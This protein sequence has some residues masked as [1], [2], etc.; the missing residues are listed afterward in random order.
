MKIIL[1]PKDIDEIKQLFDFECDILL[2]TE[3]ILEFFLARPSCLREWYVDEEISTEICEYLLHQFA[4]WV[5]EGEPASQHNTYF[6]PGLVQPWTWPEEQSTA[7]Y[8]KEF[9]EAFLRVAK[10]KGISLREDL[11]AVQWQ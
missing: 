8:E 1:E 3:Q 7:E 5:L 6:K 9:S 2:T 10:A 4:G 11:W